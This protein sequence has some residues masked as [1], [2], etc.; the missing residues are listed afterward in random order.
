MTKKKEMQAV[1]IWMIFLVLT[2]P[3]YGASVFAAPRIIGVTVTGNDGV[4]GFVRTAEDE[5]LNIEVTGTLDA[6]DMA[7]DNVGLIYGER[8]YRFGE[9]D[10]CTAFSEPSCTQLQ[11]SPNEKIYKCTCIEEPFVRDSQ[12]LSFGIFDSAG[13]LRARQSKTVSPDEEKPVVTF[14]SAVQKQNEDN[15]TV[16]LSASDSGS[17]IKRIELY[18][19]GKKIK[20]MAVNAS[21]YSKTFEISLSGDKT[22]RICAK[23][24][25]MMHNGGSDPQHES[26]EKC[27]EVTTDFSKPDICPN[28]RFRVLQGDN[29]VSYISTESVLGEFNGTVVVEI[30]DNSL[31]TESITADL[32]ELNINPLYSG[33]RKLTC[34]NS[35]TD[36][37]VCTTDIKIRPK[38]TSPKITVWADDDMGHSA[39]KECT[40]SFQLDNTKP[41]AVF[42]GTDHCLE[43][44][45]YLGP[46]ETNDARSRIVARF[47]EF[48]SGLSNEWVYFELSSLNPALYS[49]KRLQVY[50]CTK[51]WEC[52]GY[53]EVEEDKRQNAARYPVSI[54]Y[55]SV[56][57]AGNPVEGQTTATL[58]YDGEPPKLKNDVSILTD[59]G[60]DFF[61]TGD[62]LMIEATLVDDESGVEYA[63]ADFKD[64]TG[65]GNKTRADCTKEDDEF[66][67]R[68]TVYNIAGPKT[69]ATLEFDFYDFGGNPLH[70]ETKKFDVAEPVDE[71]VS[72]WKVVAVET[73]PSIDKMTLDLVEHR[74]YTTVT[75]TRDNTFVGNPNVEVLKM[76][77]PICEGDSLFLADNPRLLKIYRAGIGNVPVVI[78]Q[79]NLK[80]VKMDPSIN[81][82][83]LICSIT[84]LTRI[85]SGANWK[86]YPAETD[87]FNYTISLYNQA[88]G[89]LDD[90]V[91]QEILRVGSNKLISGKA[92]VNLKSAAD[93]GEKLCNIYSALNSVATILHSA[94]IIICALGYTEVG[95][96][97]IRAADK[98][99]TKMLDSGIGRFLSGFCKL[100]SCELGAELWGKV[101]GAGVD[102]WKQ[103]VYK[104]PQESLVTSII[105][106]CPSGIIYNLDKARQI[107]CKYVSC[108]RYEVPYGESVQTCV[109]MRQYDWCVY[110]TREKAFWIPFVGFLNNFAKTLAAMA[111]NIP[112]LI[113]GIINAASAFV[114]KDVGGAG[115]GSEDCTNWK[116][117]ACNSWAF[118]KT[119]I[120]L[121]N[122]LDKIA[123]WKSKESTG[124]GDQCETAFRDW[125]KFVAGDAP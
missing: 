94:G 110:V 96:K 109:K 45:C 117:I 73:T 116:L 107:E 68:W 15:V 43:G 123:M 103:Y 89:R 42:L 118:V 97:L 88:V 99:K 18:D 46:R 32:S 87:Y 53:A 17:G 41:N 112:S 58:V 31:K 115:S 8:T 12:T 26:S 62:N 60:L 11:S 80:K 124:T 47:E 77:E 114:C 105:N 19:D 59:D 86:L 49:G 54:I 39:E 50:E 95:G 102:A 14:I 27:S 9:G 33:S 69:G 78:I 2:I 101:T 28:G 55:P 57:N 84:S 63:M 48:Q 44:Q 65:N 1:A 111:T 66:K 52:Y 122:L 91:K 7:P 30:N 74:T 61:A 29:D 36:S 125:D 119:S 10:F 6:E 106:I 5:R 22:R 23:A 64:I 82:I 76:E 85:K 100:V 24:F 72:F 35:G 92:I 104:D 21:S 67:C 3:F 16:V 90:N 120:K 75:M 79:T 4:D 121:Y 20:D 40:I 70:N 83:T 37:Y 38:S 56:D 81:N 108:L 34:V 93:F 51:G 71:D 113:G 98:I 13:K 25:D